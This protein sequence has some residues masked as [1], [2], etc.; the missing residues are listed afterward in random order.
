MTERNTVIRSLHDLGL[1]AWF[2][3]ALAGAVGIN[4][5][6][7]DLPDERMRLRVASA[8]WDRWTPVNLTAIAA[9]LVGSAGLAY[10]NKSRIAAQRGV[11]AS[12]LAKTA[13]TAAALGV[14][15]YSRALGRRLD[16]AG[17]TPVEG[18]TEPGPSTP[19]EVARAQRQLRICQWLVPALTGGI[20]VL[21]AVHGE[22]Q[23]PGQQ[24]SGILSKPAQLLRAAA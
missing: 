19:P 14:T 21:N 15:A 10:A 1:G 20:A 16:R 11:G 8:G 24:V 5:A 18:S 4:G 22:Q 17:D 12:S 9:H 6:S 23:R 3:G 2:G 7:A 13:L